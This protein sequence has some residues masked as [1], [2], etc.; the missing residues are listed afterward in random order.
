VAGGGT[1]GWITAG[2]IAARHHAGAE[3][4]IT[5]T[6]VESPNVPIIGVGEGTWP[7]MR[8]TLRSMGVSETEFVRECDVSFKQGARF[9][10]WASGADDDAYYHPLVLPQGFLKGNLVPHWQERR[11]DR[12][13][14]EAVCTQAAICDRNLAPKQIATP[15]FAGV[16]NYAYHLN[17]GK[18][19]GFLQ[20]HCCSK[21]GV[22]HVVDDVT[23]VV[24]RSNG[25]ISA[26]MTAH[27]GSIEGDLFVDCTGFRSL[28]LGQHYGVPFR[29][30]KQVLFVDTA[31]AV[32]VPYQ[33]EGS[34]IVSHTVSTAQEAGWIW[35]I[36]LSSRRGVGHVYSSAHTSTEAAE[37]ALLDYIRPSVPDVA[38]L[39]VRRIDINPG[40][41]ARFWERNCVAVG[42][43]AGFLEPLEASALVLVELAAGM[44]A[45]QL[46]VTREAMDII[47]RRF[48][49]KFLYRWD[50]IIDFLKLHYV[51]STRTDNAFWID[52]RAA[53]TIPDSLG[54]LLELWKHQYPWHGDFVQ[55][56]EV[57]PAA[58]YQYVLYGMGFATQPSH[59]GRSTTERQFAAEQFEENER[60]VC[61]LLAALPSNRE[62]LQAVRSYGMPKV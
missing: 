27:N 58:S 37:K 7:T 55:K 51:L 33:S 13:F 57:F 56:D 38:A 35:D 50:R 54:E 62:L 25:D 2:V 31:L 29:S 5:V 46:P 8:S 45:E 18:F 44:I 61:R 17:A 47:A 10:R 14:A 60:M 26:L 52:N 28:L 9:Q 48:N 6:L 20:R 23:S 11:G 32:Q 39:S 22:R 34:P 1:A 16:V 4:A 40:H 42:L 43:S 41:R 15:E 59:L 3:G 49:D 21:L 53:S 30:R 19:A 24:T 36:G 12:P